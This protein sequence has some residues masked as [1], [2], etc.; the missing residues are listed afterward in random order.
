MI[1]GMASK[2]IA[3]G[4]FPLGMDNRVADYDLA[5][6][7]GAGHLLRD[8]LNVDVTAR[9]AV[10]TR[11]GYALAVAGADVHSL[12]APLDGAFALYVDNGAIYRLS[13]DGGTSVVATGFGAITPVRYAQVNEAIYFTDGIRVG[14]YHP[15]PGPTPAWGTAT[16]G[17]VGEQALVPMPPGAGI[18]H[19]GAR[20]LVALG[21][22]LVYSEPFVPH[23]RDEARGFELFAAP[24]TCIAAVEA[25]VFVVADKTYFIAGG[26]PAQSVRVVLDY[27]APVQAAG[28]RDDGGAHWM[29]ARGVV[30]VART[31]EIINT[32]EAHVALQADGAAA[33]LHREAD[34]MRAIIAALS[35]PS[36]TGAGVGSYAQ[37]RIIRKETS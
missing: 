30:S 29:S 18:A 21:T 28:Y 35:E 7:D 2:P 16:P 25:G 33:T 3:I 36:N 4:P 15:A 13:A 14:S 6:P 11:R 9:G 1:R 23:L 24:I 20:L 8:A 12:W 34:G 10:K 27:G 32:Q 19:H 31:G 26:L 5:L 37:A 22:A 17:V